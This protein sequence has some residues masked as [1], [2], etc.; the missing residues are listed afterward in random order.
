MITPESY[1]K[2]IGIDLKATSLLSYIDGAMR[3]PNL[4]HIMEGY[5]MAKQN[6][7]DNIEQDINKHVVEESLNGTTSL[8]ALM[9]NNKQNRDGSITES[10]ESP[11]LDNH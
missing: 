1:L 10:D 7:I 4:C 2:S 3:S 8:S 11:D 5:T 6:E 9:S